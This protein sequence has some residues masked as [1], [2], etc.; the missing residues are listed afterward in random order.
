VDAALKVPRLIKRYDN[1]KLY[2]VEARRYVTVEEL[3]RMVG[4]GDELRV[5]HQTSGDDLTAVVLAQVLLEGIKQRTAQIP[6]QVLARLIRLGFR[7]ASTLAQWT[8]PQEAARRARD[9]AERIASGLVSRGR[10]TIEE[11]LALRQEIAGSVQRLVSE[12]QRGLE[13]RFRSLLDGSERE[14]GVNPALKTLRERLLSLESYLAPP[15]RGGRKPGRTRG[16]ARARRS[17]SR[18]RPGLM[19]RRKE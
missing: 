10:L 8:V 13:S 4:R 11:A 15:A 16:P 2:D 19:P 18:S 3:G 9:E 1:R 17:R 12:A 7:P 5:L 14:G 6:W